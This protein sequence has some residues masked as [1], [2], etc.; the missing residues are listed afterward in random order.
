[1]AISPNFQLHYPW[2]ADMQNENNYDLRWPGSD[3]NKYMILWIK[4]E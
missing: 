2:K 4:L 1:L 3:Q